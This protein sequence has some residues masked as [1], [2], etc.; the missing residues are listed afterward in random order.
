MACASINGIK[1]NNDKRN[2]LMSAVS[3]PLLSSLKR[4][5]VYLM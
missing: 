5:V 3:Y 1:T 4:D 2:I